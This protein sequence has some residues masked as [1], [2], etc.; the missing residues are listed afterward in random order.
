M[1]FTINIECS[2]EEAREF[3]AIPDPEKVQEMMVK[4]M[5]D[6]MQ[7][8]MPEMPDNFAESMKHWQN[9]QQMFLK[10]MMTPMGS[11]STSSKDKKSDDK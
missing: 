5:T 1:K 2:P 10:Q 7:G 11:S 3:L 9:V 8:H 6:N 4:A